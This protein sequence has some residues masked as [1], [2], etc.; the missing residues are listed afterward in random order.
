MPARE[1][2]KK[3]TAKLDTLSLTQ[4]QPRCGDA[5][6]LE[7]RE[8]VGLAG[9]LSPLLAALDHPSRAYDNNPLFVVR[10]E[11]R[12]R[13]VGETKSQAGGRGGGGSD[14]CHSSCCR[15]HRNERDHTQAL[16][17]NSEACLQS[18]KGSGAV[19]WPTAFKISTPTAQ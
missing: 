14:V 8:G 4:R 13:P 19:P 2:K 16:V 3:R 12:G 7:G 5:E 11:P 1:E 6:P 10:K 18:R 17:L 15:C 9:Q